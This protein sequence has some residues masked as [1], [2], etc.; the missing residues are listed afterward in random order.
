MIYLMMLSVAQIMPH[1]TVG[2]LLTN[3]SDRMWRESLRVQFEVPSQ[4]VPAEREREREG[5][6]P[7]HSQFSMKHYSGENMD[8]AVVLAARNVIIIQYINF[9]DN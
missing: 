5:S 4:N 6:H 8:H 9:Y 7:N 2:W 1:R 3:T